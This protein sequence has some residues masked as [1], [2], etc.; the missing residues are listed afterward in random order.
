MT[1]CDFC[2]TI[3]AKSIRLSRDTLR[4]FDN[5]LVCCVDLVALLRQSGIQRMGV[6]GDRWHRANDTKQAVK[7]PLNN[8]LNVRTMYRRLRTHLVDTDFLERPN[9]LWYV[10]PPVHSPMANKR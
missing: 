7:K 9:Q 2:S 10:S 5:A 6:L 1:Y 8:D 3:G 4:L